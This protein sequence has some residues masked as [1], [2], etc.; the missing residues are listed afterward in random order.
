VFIDDATGQTWDVQL[1][2]TNDASYVQDWID[3][4]PDGHI[5]VTSEL[6]ER[7]DLPDSH[8]TNHELT[9]RTD[10]V[11][12]RLVDTDHDSDIWHY[13]PAM[14]AAS[15]SLVVWALWQRYRSGAISLT[16]FK[17]MV[18]RA[19]GMKVA[20]I[21]LLSV[22]MAIPGLNVVTGAAL[23]AKLLFSSANVVRV[24]TRASGMPRGVYA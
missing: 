3:G 13:F 21:A 7:M 2:A 5:V 19:T 10:D 16:Q 23:V 20:K 6:A 4:H 9:A 15:L 17:T 14:S 22:A 18:A 12:D 24:A 1:K 8:M 11:V